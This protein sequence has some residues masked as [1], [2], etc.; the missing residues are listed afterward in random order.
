[1]AAFI[2][3]IEALMLGS[4]MTFAS[5]VFTSAPSSARPSGM[6]WSG[7]S[8]SGKAAR[9]RPASEMSR[10]STG[11]PVAPAKA[12]ITGRNDSVARAGASSV[13]V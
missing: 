5:G 8:R 7:V 2:C 12:R 1:M 9:S 13:Q 4:L 6:R 11:T 10:S 3:G